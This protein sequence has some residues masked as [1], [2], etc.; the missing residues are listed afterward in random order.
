MLLGNGAVTCQDL[1]FR[2]SHV[3]N[4]QS[5][6]QVRI[7]VHTWGVLLNFW[8]SFTRPVL[9]QH[10]LLKVSNLCSL[11]PRVSHLTP[12]PPVER[13]RRW[14][15]LGMRLQ[16]CGLWFWFGKKSAYSIGLEITAALYL[17][18][19]SHI[20]CQICFLTFTITLILLCFRDTDGPFLVP[21]EACQKLWI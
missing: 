2:S 9:G 4:L 8:T 18:L 21:P 16:T 6:E 15:A 7:K 19:T 1:G 12:L 11:I 5:N 13:E 20:L 3:D 14:E 10:F 17:S